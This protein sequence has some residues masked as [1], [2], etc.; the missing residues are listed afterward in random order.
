MEYSN[1]GSEVDGANSSEDVLRIW[2]CNVPAWAHQSS[3]LWAFSV[4]FWERPTSGAQRESE[5][6]VVRVAA[7]SL[8]GVKSQETALTAPEGAGGSELSCFFLARG[9]ILPFFH[10]NSVQLIGLEAVASP[11]ARCAVS[12]FLPV[13]LGQM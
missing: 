9:A 10:G 13:P 8:F 12:D 7:V 1:E 4:F 6:T 11:L 5:T 3:V 2:V